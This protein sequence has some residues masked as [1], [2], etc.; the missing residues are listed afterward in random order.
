MSKTKFRL[1]N[2]LDESIITVL[3]PLIGAGKSAPFTANDMVNALHAAHLD[4]KPDTIKKAIKMLEVLIDYVTTLSNGKS[5]TTID[6]IEK[7]KQQLLS[8]L[9]KL[10]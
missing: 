4:N 3:N 7:V 10:A 2:Q 5:K 6:G 8:A 9:E 1:F